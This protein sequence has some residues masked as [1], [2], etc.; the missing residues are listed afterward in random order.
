MEVFKFRQPNLTPLMRRPYSWCR[1]LNFRQPNHSPLNVKII[2]LSKRFKFWDISDSTNTFGMFQ[3]I[4][5]LVSIFIR[6]IA[7]SFG[8]LERNFHGSSRSAAG[9]FR[10]SGE[11]QKYIFDGSRSA[12]GS[13]GNLKRNRNYIFHGSSRLSVF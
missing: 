7:G 9:S 10:K 13:F 5:Q 8:Y 12:A 1:S 6:S 11:K 3:R 4:S 2:E